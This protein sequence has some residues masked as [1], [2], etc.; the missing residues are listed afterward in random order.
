[1]YGNVVCSYEPV[2][3][4]RYIHGRTEAMRSTTTKVATLCKVFCSHFTTKQEKIDALIEAIS[5]HSSCVRDCAAGKGVDRHLFA[6]KNIAAKHNI[7]TP[8]FYSSES[9]NTMNHTI[10]STSNCGNPSLRLFGF[11]PVVPD[12]FG[13]G[14]II[15][16]SLIA[17]SISSKHRQTKRFVQVLRQTLYLIQDLLGVTKSLQVSNHTKGTISEVKESKNNLE[18]LEGYGDTYGEGIPSLKIS[19]SITRNLSTSSTGA[20]LANVTPRESMDA[21]GSIGKQFAEE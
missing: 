16:E 13:V 17:Y 19:K 11:G 7:D 6:L 14:Y 9:W 18:Y 1:M 10:I 21:L 15:K 20:P 3:T 5:F 2:L 4:K 8:A 12:G